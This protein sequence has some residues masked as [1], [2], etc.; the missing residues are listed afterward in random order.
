MS[1]VRMKTMLG[2]A[3]SAWAYV[4]ML[5]EVP[6]ESTTTKATEASDRTVFFIPFPYSNWTE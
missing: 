2:L 3:V 6:K 5:L 1:S 4:G